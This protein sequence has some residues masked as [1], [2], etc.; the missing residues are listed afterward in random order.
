MPRPFP[1][2]L[3]KHSTS[4]HF[5]CKLFLDKPVDGEG[6]DRE[7]PLHLRPVRTMQAVERDWVRIVDAVEVRPHV[8]G[9]FGSVR[10]TKTGIHLGTV[11]FRHFPVAFARDVL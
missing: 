11:Q 3:T 2:Y 4:T 7:G 5:V 1:D 9:E 6:V 8:G 10:A